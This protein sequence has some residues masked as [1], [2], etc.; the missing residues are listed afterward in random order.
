MENKLKR[1]ENENSLIIKNEINKIIN[2]F[3]EREFKEALQLSIEMDKKYPDSYIIK[4]ILKTKKTEKIILFFISIQ[5][6][7]IINIKLVHS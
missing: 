6:F 2:H 5:F 4:N 1:K 3:T 7:L